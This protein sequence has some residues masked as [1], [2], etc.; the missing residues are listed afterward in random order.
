MVSE[1]IITLNTTAM[2]SY[3]VPVVLKYYSMQPRLC[4]DENGLNLL[5]F[6]LGP[7]KDMKILKLW[8]LMQSSLVYIG[9]LRKI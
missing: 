5:G 1:N 3:H 2:F 9:L 7:G 8:D 4:I 6:C